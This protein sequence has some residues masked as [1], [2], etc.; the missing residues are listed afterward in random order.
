MVTAICKEIDLQKD[1][2]TNKNLTTI[3]FGGGT[4]SLLETSEI[5]QILERLSKNYSWENN[6]EITLEANPD[7]ITTEKISKLRAGGVNRLSIGIQSF[8]D[9]ELLA[10]NRAHNSDESLKAVQICQDAGIDNL[11]IDIIYGMPGS[12]QDSWQYNIDKALE[13]DV[14]HISSYALTVEP[15][16]FLDHMVKKGGILLPKEMEVNKQYLQL[17]H[18]LTTAGYDHYEISNFAKPSKYAVHNTNYWMSVPYLGLGPSAHSYQ[19]TFRQWNINNNAKYIKSIS[20]GVIPSEREQTKY[21][22]QFN[23]YIMTRLR[24]M[25][26]VDL[27]ELNNRFSSELNN[28]QKNI[29][30][31]IKSQ[32]VLLE[33]NHYRL[34]PKG[35]LLADGIASD[36]FLVEE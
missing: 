6:I 31:Y 15:K 3:Y 24:T 18:S 4:P 7:D 32:H 2:L 10:S 17:I 25:W 27:N 29:A 33:D 13:L 9:G 26:G 22:D 28:V 35:K 21:A 14:D 11:S 23:E 12:T 36:L 8:I 16:T 30:K 34:T 19:P 5:N 1:F 20:K